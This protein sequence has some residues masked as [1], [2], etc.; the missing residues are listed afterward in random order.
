MSQQ[1]SSQ[2]PSHAAAMASARERRNHRSQTVS[3]IRPVVVKP[4]GSDRM[5]TVE[6][7]RSPSAVVSQVSR[8]G[9]LHK[10]SQ[11]LRL[12]RQRRQTHTS[13]P[14]AK[15][16]THKV[17]SVPTTTPPPTTTT[18][19]TKGPTCTTNTLADHQSVQDVRAPTRLCEVR[20]DDNETCTP[21]PLGP[22][23]EEPVDVPTTTVEY[24]NTETETSQTPPRLIGA[25]LRLDTTLEE[26]DGDEG[27]GNES[28]HV[29]LPKPCPP[30][31]R[32]RFVGWLQSPRG[33]G[34]TNTE[35][36]AGT[37]DTTRGMN[38]AGMD[39]MSGRRTKPSTPRTPRTLL[40]SV[41]SLA[42]PKISR[43]KFNWNSGAADIGSDVVERD[44][45]S[46]E[47]RSERLNNIAEGAQ[48]NEIQERGPQPKSTGGWGIGRLMP[49]LRSPRHRPTSAQE[50]NGDDSARA[51]RSMQSDI[52]S[53]L[54]A[55]R[56]AINGDD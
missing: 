17:Y 23:R 35:G 40:A 42:S 44:I 21:E 20:E 34:P 52:R 27:E 38:S 46:N 47:P 12:M 51:G 55:R 5:I 48:E 11:R 36:V 1:P 9:S 26:Y 32:S 29:P 14:V 33:K 6:R 41:M 13:S 2:S 54:K 49:Q 39:G 10:V 8:S 7:T 24:G 4:G 45:P 18:S 53:M 30:P 37:H 31:L 15:S 16:K 22:S 28:A 25:G 19:A 3:G 56:R 50:S 43:P